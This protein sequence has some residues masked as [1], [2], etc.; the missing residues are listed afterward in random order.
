MFSGCLLDSSC[1]MKSSSLVRSARI[2][3]TRSCVCHRRQICPLC[4][5]RLTLCVRAYQCRCRCPR[6]HTWLLL[7]RLTALRTA[8]SRFTFISMAFSCRF[9]HNVVQA[10]WTIPYA[11]CSIPNHD[12]FGASGALQNNTRRKHTQC[13]R[14]RARREGDRAKLVIGVRPMIR[15]TTCVDFASASKGLVVFLR[16]V[17]N[18]T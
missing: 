12:N 7:L 11:I 6:R 15:H 5:L 3:S 9:S 4:L 13:A 8:S 1:C 14:T 2:A 10:R 18:I 17:H 16:I